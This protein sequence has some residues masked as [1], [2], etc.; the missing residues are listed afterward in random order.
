MMDPLE[1]KFLPALVGKR[2]KRE[3]LKLE[4]TQY[5]L[6]DEVGW[7]PQEVSQL[8]AGKRKN[9][10]VMYLYKISKVLGCTIEDLVTNNPW[11]DGQDDKV[12]EKELKKK[13]KE[14]KTERFKE[15]MRRMGRQE[16]KKMWMKQE[17]R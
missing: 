2:V 17:E 4:L 11:K 7:S 9:N 10:F 5:E 13:L 1:E 16:I 8:E 15:T 12:D 14:K 6:A 3:R